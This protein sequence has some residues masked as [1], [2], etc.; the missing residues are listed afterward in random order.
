MNLKLAVSIFAY[1][2][3]GAILLSYFV[4]IG[5][6]LCARRSLT[7]IEFSDRMKR[8]L[9]GQTIFNLL[10]MVVGFGTWFWACQSM[11][12]YATSECF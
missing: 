6:F 12:R 11:W 5:L 7:G 9:I 8:N 3:I 4:Y 2:L 10:I 1:A